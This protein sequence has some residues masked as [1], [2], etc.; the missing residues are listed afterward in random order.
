MK[1]G[2]FPFTKPHT[3]AARS[4]E[5]QKPHIPAPSQGGKPTKIEV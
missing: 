3:Q 1:A 5:K 4:K 2:P